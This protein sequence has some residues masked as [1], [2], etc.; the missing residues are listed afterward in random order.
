MQKKGSS[1][2]F[3]HKDCQYYPCHKGIAPEQLNCLFCF[4]PLYPLGENC[5]GNFRL[6]ERGGKDCSACLYPHRHE[7]YPDIVS[8]LSELCR[9]FPPPPE[10]D[11]DG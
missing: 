7:N 10:Q 11:Q 9:C 2:F 3:S 6:L 4:C 1:S 5:G 8:R